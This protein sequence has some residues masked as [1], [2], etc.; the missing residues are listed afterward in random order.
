[1]DKDWRNAFGILMC[2]EI[3]DGAGAGICDGT[4]HLLQLNLY[5]HRYLQQRTCPNSTRTV[6]WEHSLPVQALSTYVFTVTH[7][8]VFSI[9]TWF[10]S[11][12]SKFCESEYMEHWPR[13]ILR[14]NITSQ[15][16]NVPGMKFFHQTVFQLLGKITEPWNIGHTD[17]DLFL[18]QSSGHT[19]VII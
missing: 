14:L 13:Y 17:L 7:Q 5:S 4:I 16:T 1:M 15:G 3:C 12:Y 9:F 10:H 2:T 19:E 8:N 18:C 11:T 6:A